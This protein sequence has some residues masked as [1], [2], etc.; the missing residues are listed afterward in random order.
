MQMIQ[1]SNALQILDHYG[2][3]VDTETGFPHWSTTG[4]TIRH[5]LR[6]DQQEMLLKMGWATHAIDRGVERAHI[7]DCE[8]GALLD[9]LLTARRRYGTCIS[10]D[11]YKAPHPKDRNDDLSVTAG[12]IA[13]SKV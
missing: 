4:N 2:L 12:R 10:Q 1:R 7:I 6:H 3:N 13:E 8:D 9:E 5:H 11:G